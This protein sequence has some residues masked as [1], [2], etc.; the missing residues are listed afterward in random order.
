MVNPKS[1]INL[2]QKA[3]HLKHKGY[4]V[5]EA[6]TMLML[7]KSTVWDWYNDRKRNSNNQPISYVKKSPEKKHEF[8]D[9]TDFLQNLAPIHCEY[10]K[11]PKISHS[12]NKLALVIG[13]THFGCE[14]QITIDLFLKTVEELSPELI[15][16]NGDMMDF[17][18]VSK[19]PK[20]IRYSYSLSEERKRYHVFLKT[21]HEIT[22]SYGSMILETN[23][24][25]SGS[26]V[27]SR[28]MRYLSNQLGQIG[29][30]NDAIEALSYENIFL[31]KKE[32]S[33]VKLVEHVQIGDDFFIMHGDVVRKRGGMS[34][35][36]MM[37]K[38]NTSV[39][40]N[41]THRGGMSVK[42]LPGI[43]TKKDK[44]IK[45]YENFCACSL[46]PVYASAPDWANGFSIVNYS[47]SNIAVELCVVENN[48]VAIS[49]LG[50]TLS[51]KDR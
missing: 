26:G 33:R 50:K 10:Q 47:D 4:S 29:D 11:K 41:H 43:G 17:L 39:M 48:S 42:R 49:T 2:K 32:W 20:D 23:G 12:A 30:L 6:A 36:G 15:V 44:F 14:D 25:H 31:P 40:M 19:Y 16:L 7:P 1:Q 13:D 46:S 45:C 35:M 51:I 8:D 18:A 24:N 5:S 22:S 28:W 38:L 9:I 27:E 37:D 3:L 34:G 21:L